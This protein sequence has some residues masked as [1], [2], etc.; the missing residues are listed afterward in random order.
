MASNKVKLTLVSFLLVFASATSYIYF[1][2]YQPKALKKISEVRGV[3]TINTDE[4][5]YPT[6]AQKLGFYQT[7]TSKQTTFQTAKTLIEI[8][9]FYNNIFTTKG[10]ELTLENISDS[11]SKHVYQKRNSK[12]TVVATTQQ[13]Q[14]TVVGIEVTGNE[15]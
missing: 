12:A 5:P 4:I 14:T 2:K 8:Q 15:L 3:S 10:W 1:I 6:D 9:Q 13:D 11:T 7:P